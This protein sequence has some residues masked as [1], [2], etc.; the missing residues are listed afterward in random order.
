[1]YLL[2]KIFSKNLQELKNSKECSFLYSAKN[3]IIAS[4]GFQF[5]S[6]INFKDMNITAN[7]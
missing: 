5:R 1:M 2:L 7:F 4:I 3:R 6:I